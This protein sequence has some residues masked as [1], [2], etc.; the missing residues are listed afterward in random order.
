MYEISKDFAFEASHRLD[1]LPEEHQCARLHGHSY[2][3]RVILA[4]N[5]LDEHGFILDYGLLKPFGA[6][7]D[8]HL[9][10]RY[11]NDV[12]PIQPSAENMARHLHGV[13]LDLVPLPDGV[14]ASVAVSETQKTWASYRPVTA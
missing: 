10:H 9:D 6:W 7:V 1:G 5:A 8:A 4:G 12:L 13:L 3:V 11:L 14:A 2:R